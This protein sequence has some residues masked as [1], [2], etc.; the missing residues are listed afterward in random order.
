[1]RLE[2]GPIKRGQV[3]KRKANGMKMLITSRCEKGWRGLCQSEGKYPQN[4]SFSEF[5][6][7]KFYEKV[8][9]SEKIPGLPEP[10]EGIRFWN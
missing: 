3:W 7:Y 6:I 2:Q 10:N 5:D 8:N 9:E 4:H 1:M